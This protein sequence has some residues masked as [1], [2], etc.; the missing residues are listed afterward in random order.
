MK[1]H[2]VLLSWFLCYFI[3]LRSKYSSCWRNVK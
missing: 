3:S 2:I 1:L